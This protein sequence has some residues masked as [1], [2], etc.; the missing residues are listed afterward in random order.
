MFQA[1]LTNEL[2]MYS[3]YNVLCLMAITM[4]PISRMF[5]E[6]IIQIFNNKHVLALT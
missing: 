1:L 5:Y 2:I 3:S 4:G 6:H